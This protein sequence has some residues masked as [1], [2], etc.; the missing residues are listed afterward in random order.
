MVF[1]IKRIDYCLVAAVEL[2]S[3]PVHQK[4][5]NAGGLRL[6]RQEA[7]SIWR[8]SRFAMSWIARSH[9]VRSNA[10]EAPNREPGGD[11]LD[12]LTTLA[13]AYE[14]KGFPDGCFPMD[15]ANPIE[16]ILSA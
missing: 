12:V 14:E 16:A 6:D 2:A 13:E 9:C 3:D 8:L 4:D 7:G 5:W 11:R 15:V 1:D 10:Y